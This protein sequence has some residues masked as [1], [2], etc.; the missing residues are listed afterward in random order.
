MSI[1]YLKIILFSLL[2][3]IT[4]FLPISSSGHLIILHNLFNDSILNN[5]SF[6]I[7]LHSGSL[8]AIIIYFF[9]DIINIIKNFFNKLLKN[10]KEI[11]SDMGF[12]IIIATIPAGLI[13]YF[14]DDIIEGAFRAPHVVAI[15]LIIGSII[16]I[17]AEKLYRPNKEIKNIS[18]LDSIFIGVLQCLAFIPG[19]SR[20]GITISSGMFRG[21]NRQES[22][23]FSFLLAIPVIFGAFIKNI[24]EIN[25]TNLEIYSLIT[26]FVFCFLFSIISIKILFLLL[27]KSLGLYVFAIYRIILALIILIFLI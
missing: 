2:Q 6:D 1:L 23:R 27:K 20:S 18:P 13:G 19:I 11:K 12:L 4:E 3:A 26:A 14:F 22:A 17:L 5:A 10:T 16:F 25:K 8:L 7:V 9:K 21:L 24:F 15:A